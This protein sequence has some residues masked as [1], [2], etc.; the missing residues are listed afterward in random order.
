MNKYKNAIKAL[1]FLLGVITIGSFTQRALAEDIE[2]YFQKNPEKIN[3]MFILD[4]SE[5]M[6][7]CHKLL[8]DPLSCRK[9]DR[10]LDVLKRSMNSLLED[11]YLVDSNQTDRKDIEI[12]VGIGALTGSTSSVLEQE[13]DMSV[14]RG[15]PL[16]SNSA[17][18]YVLY[19]LRRLSE[20]VEAVGE[21]NANAVVST[22]TSLGSNPKYGII[23]QG[24]SNNLSGKTAMGE[25]QFPYG[26]SAD[27]NFGAIRFVGLNIPRYAVIEEAKIV[28]PSKK[29][30]G[31]SCRNP[32]TAHCK[33]PDKMELYLDY[34][35]GEDIPNFNG[36][37]VDGFDKEK[38]IGLDLFSRTWVP[39]EAQL[40]NKT[41]QSYEKIEL[42]IMEREKVTVNVEPFITK[43]INNANWCGSEEQKLAIA[44]HHT[45]K[46]ENWFR[47]PE[48]G[49]PELEIKWKPGSGEKLG[50]T[51]GT[52]TKTINTAADNA[53]EKFTNG[54]SSSVETGDEATT[55][56][57]TEIGTKDS[58]V[59]GYRFEGVGLDSGD[60]INKAVLA[61]PVHKNNVGSIS[62]NNDLEVLVRRIADTSKFVDETKSK[63]KENYQGIWNRDIAYFDQ[64]IEVLTENISAL[65]EKIEAEEDSERKTQ[66][67][68][69][70]QNLENERDEL[71][72]SRDEWINASDVWISKGASVL[73]KINKSTISGKALEGDFSDYRLLELDVTS[74][75]VQSLCQ[76]DATNPENN[77]CSSGNVLLALREIREV[78]N[79]GNYYPLTLTMLG[80]TDPGPGKEEI[81]PPAALRLTV[82]S[83]DGSR[84]ERK[85]YQK[86]QKVIDQLTYTGSLQYKPMDAA[87]LEMARYML[88]GGNGK[89]VDAYFGNGKHD[90]NG[91]GLIQNRALSHESVLTLT[92]PEREESSGIIDYFRK[93]NEYLN[94]LNDWKAQVKNKENHYINSTLSDFH[95]IDKPETCEKNAII[96]VTDGRFRTQSRSKVPGLLADPP[97]NINMG[98]AKLDEDDD[99]FDGNHAELCDVGFFKGLGQAMDPLGLFSKN[100]GDKAPYQCAAILANHLANKGDYGSKNKNN[101]NIKNNAI[102]THMIGFRLNDDDPSKDK[103]A[104]ETL[105][106]MNI[107]T[108][109]G[110]GLTESANTE[111]ELLRALTKIVNKVAFENAAMA[112]PGIGIDQSTQLEHLDSLYYALFKPRNV[113][114][115]PGNLKKYRLGQTENDDAFQILDANNEPAIDERTGLFKGTAASF[116]SDV[117]ITKDDED[118][119]IEH[120][121]PDGNDAEKGGARAVLDRNN[122][123]KLFVTEGKGSPSSNKF[124]HDIGKASNNA[125][126]LSSFEFKDGN[127]VHDWLKT[128]WGDAIHS[129]PQLINYT[130]GENTQ[131][132]VIYVSD[133]NGMLHAIDAD[134]GE[135]YFA[136]SPKEE[137]DKAKAR[138]NRDLTQDPFMSIAP[139][140]KEAEVTSPQPL[141]PL[142]DGFASD[143]D[144]IANFYGLDSTWTFWRVASTESKNADK[145][146][147]FGGQ[148]RGGD[149]YYALD[150]SDLN[151]PKLLW[152]ISSNHVGYENLGQTWSE[153][154]L[155]KIRIDNKDVPVVVFAGGYDDE[156]N[157]LGRGATGGVQKGND[158]YI[159][160][161]LTGAQLWR[162]SA[163]GGSAKMRYSIPASPALVDVD[164]DGYFDYIYV[165]DMGGQV[166]RVSLNNSKHS[167]LDKI[168]EVVIGPHK[169]ASLAGMGEAEKRRF[170]NTPAVSIGAHNDRSAIQVVIGSGYRA[171]PL[172]TDVNERVYGF[173]DVQTGELRDWCSGNSDCPAEITE[174]HLKVSSENDVS[175]FGWFVS[176]DADKGEKSLSEP[177]IVDGKVFFTTFNTDLNELSDACSVV[178]G[179]SRLYAL[180]LID[181][182][183]VMEKDGGFGGEGYK[184]LNTVGIPPKPQILL[185]NKQLTGEEETIDSCNRTLTGVVGTE[186]F[187]LGA[188]NLCGVQR[189][190]WFESTREKAD[191]LLQKKTSSSADAG[192]TE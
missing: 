120:Y 32:L 67:N 155:G 112:A 79:K 14:G 182:S 66:L 76:L 96:M 108:S 157:D 103:Y 170:Y 42:N 129:E 20:E 94:E 12:N 142:R 75:V 132:N 72:R 35:F 68:L 145:V 135:E 101:K 27:D 81:I 19:P 83:N 127:D 174:E 90:L 178:I 59:A 50:E 117:F 24:Y 118:N 37:N 116:W 71:E 186:V 150:V 45:K 140:K 74:L 30:A 98:G 106:A 169:I 77:K 153:P 95:D 191:K 99:D 141:E 173:L 143:T 21:S 78:G 128:A 122:A 29:G 88:S 80:K 124:E 1:V 16:S 38:E 85:E 123:R 176:L 7:R 179:K 60:R 137:M 51:C 28:F 102:S 63:Q 13:D 34:D 119:D 180:N 26:E 47:F 55:S 43:I 134:S 152:Q 111:E 154:K 192:A 22:F 3:L 31:L 130:V 8:I 39:T 147:A 158:I 183:P 167:G 175:S 139:I 15:N 97:F 65:E 162:A 159:V 149:N 5:T 177:V 109:A 156:E 110:D 23:T 165:G 171:H 61:I 53:L 113:S 52:S 49:W 11:L 125:T 100:F 48:G 115:W 33:G 10:R 84:Y 41:Y 133:N 105:A 89:T 86:M 93:L 181:G 44:F 136:F 9:R 17:G 57:N 172:S 104:K 18:G 107:V 2:L 121:F 69:E 190:R 114:V 62:S 6:R 187:N 146:F 54:K 40:T 82:S 126:K 160:N 189:T 131:K 4:S 185:I 166:F 188:T 151:G 91:V 25:W 92:R 87:Y 70:K 163:N 73:D 168:D 64:N 36:E 164:S 184:E 138:M 144:G 148:R 56:L 161:A 46:H 58:Y